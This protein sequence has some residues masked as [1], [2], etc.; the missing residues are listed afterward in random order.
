VAY[1]GVLEELGDEVLSKVKRVA[2]T[3]AGALLAL[4][5]G[6]NLTRADIVDLLNIPYDTLLDEDLVLT[7]T[8]NI[9]IL[10]GN[11]KYKK[12]TVKDIVLEALDRLREYQKMDEIK[13]A[14]KLINNLSRFVKNIL[15]YIG[16]RF[17]KNSLV[18]GVVSNRVASKVTKWLITAL[19]PKP[20]KP[21]VK[22][23]TKQSSIEKVLWC[24]L[25]CKISPM[26]HQNPLIQDQIHHLLDTAM[27]SA[28]K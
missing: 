20:H 1:I 5:L 17:E 18:T 14:E 19:A 11:Y 15:K 23:P 22:V 2:G 25:R 10:I 13:D 9:N 27:K 28:I 24:L 4:A 21:Q 12:F 6:L 26:Y 3:S 7:V 16:I 8:T